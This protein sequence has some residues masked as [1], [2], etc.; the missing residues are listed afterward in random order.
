MMKAEFEQRIGASISRAD[1]AIVQHVYMWHPAIP[2]VVGKDK[3]ADLYLIG[4]MDVIL[5]MDRRAIEVEKKYDELLD[6][7]EET[8]EMLEGLGKRIAEINETIQQLNAEKVR[9]AVEYNNLRVRLK[10]IQKTMKEM[11]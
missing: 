10:E 2:N 3:I 6:Q 11:V 1:Y 7:Q 5:D 9:C 4:G 8:A